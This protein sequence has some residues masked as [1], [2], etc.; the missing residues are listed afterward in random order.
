MI[1]NRAISIFIVYLHPSIAKVIHN[2]KIMKHL[3]IL[4]S[5]DNDGDRH[6]HYRDGSVCNHQVAHFVTALIVVLCKLHHTEPKIFLESP[7]L[8]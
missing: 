2:L 6:E 7:L 5:Q 4:T 3:S 8:R 1:E